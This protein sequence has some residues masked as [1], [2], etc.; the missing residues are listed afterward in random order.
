MKRCFGFSI[1][2]GIHG[3]IFAQDFSA[4]IASSDV[5]KISTARNVKGRS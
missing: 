5:N 1:D 2:I 3:Q 4:T